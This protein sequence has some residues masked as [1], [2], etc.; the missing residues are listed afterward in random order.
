M[1]DPRRDPAAVLQFERLPPPAFVEGAA[2]VEDGVQVAA[3]GERPVLQ[4]LVQRARPEGV[5]GGGR[6]HRPRPARV[7][8]GVGLVERG[9]NGVVEEPDDPQHDRQSQQQGKPNVK[10]QSPSQGKAS[11]IRRPARRTKIKTPAAAAT[12]VFFGAVDGT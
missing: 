9:E 6:A 5:P 8:S 1:V 12:G 3:E 7:G 11:S 10:T 4:H 2:V